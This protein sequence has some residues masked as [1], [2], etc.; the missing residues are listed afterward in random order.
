MAMT[1]FKFSAAVLHLVAIACIM[2]VAVHVTETAR[3][4]EDG[5]GGVLR[6]VSKWHLSTRRLSSQ[7][8]RQVSS[9]CAL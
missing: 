3:E 1:T 2:L 7:V 4:L 8:S 9:P 5:V 6:I